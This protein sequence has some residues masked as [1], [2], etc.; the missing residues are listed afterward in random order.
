MFHKTLLFLVAAMLTLSQAGA[1]DESSPGYWYSSNGTLI[2]NS[3]GECWRTS[4][5]SKANAIRACDPQLF[6]EKAVT[7]P[8]PPAQP[9]PPKA[10]KPAKPH[11]MERFTMPAVLFDFDQAVIRP[12]YSHDLHRLAMR[13]KQNPEMKL[14]LIGHTDSK[15]SAR[16]NMKLGLKRAQAVARYLQAQG[17]DAGQ[18]KA[19]SAGEG[20]PVADNATEEGRAKNRRVEFVLDY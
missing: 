4:Q 2:R 1:H 3:Y 5:W 16:Y 20:Q 18:I 10:E 15:G 17:V 9:V 7:E 13:M 19:I 6:S 8:N 12:D 11:H 14:T